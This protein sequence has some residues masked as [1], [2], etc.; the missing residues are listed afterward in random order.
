MSVLVAYASKHGATRLIAERIGD[1]LRV[2][3]L[4]VDVVAI[5]DVSDLN[6]YQ[7]FVVGGAVYVGSWLKEVTA[8]LRH[9]QALLAEHPVWLFSSGPLGTGATDAKGRDLREASVPKELET[10]AKAVHPRDHR[11]FFGALN[12]T[13]FGACERLLWMLPA[14]RS[15]LIE[16]DFRD[17]SD[18]EV[19]ATGIANELQR[20]V[21]AA[22]A[23]AGRQAP[24][25]S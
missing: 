25:G 22:P 23:S 10:V 6:N 21:G 17:W 3:G 13:T 20:D 1:A 12:H 5:N 15:L 9:Y 18:I 19:W 2:C 14:S 7:A 4:A 11:V 16:G 24:S 8:F